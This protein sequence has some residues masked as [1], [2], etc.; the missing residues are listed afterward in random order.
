MSL[1]V[2]MYQHDL[3]ASKLESRLDEV[4]TRIVSEVGVNVNTA[5]RE[6]LRRV[7]GLNRRVASSIYDRARVKPFQTRQSLLQVKGLGKKMYSQCAG[8]L[9]IP[10]GTCAYDNTNIH[11]ESYDIAELL[12]SSLTVRE[13]AKRTN[14]SV[15]DIEIVKRFLESP[16]HL[17]DPRNK[18]AIPKSRTYFTHTHTNIYKTKRNK[19]ILNR[20]RTSVYERFKARYRVEWC[21]VESDAVRFICGYRCRD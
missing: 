5:S 13:V 6:L 9:R 8:F 4:V 1:G 11:P 12:S 3:S 21:C 7:A 10:N 19:N 14:R 18:I 15:E 2:G 16:G 17:M 20:Y